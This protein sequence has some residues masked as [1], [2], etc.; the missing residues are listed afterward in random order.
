VATTGAQIE[1]STAGADAESAWEAVRNSGDIQ[2][3]PLPPFEQPEPPAWL[4]WIGEK[5]EA[6]LSPI[7]RAIGLS[8]AVMQYVLL[9]LAVAVILYLL[10]RW[11]GPILEERKIADAVPDEGWVPDRVAAQALLKDADRLAAEGRYGEAAH[12]LLQ[13]SVGHIADARPEWLRPATTSREIVAIPFLPDRARA[14]FSEIAVRVERSFFALHELD[15][16]DWTAARA[17]YADFALAE[18]SA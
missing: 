2:F 8:W 11:L 10:W 4:Q 15:R 14:A 3:Q 13:R 6:L 5:L 16:D 7:G 12:L 9:A 17:A 1:G 18:L